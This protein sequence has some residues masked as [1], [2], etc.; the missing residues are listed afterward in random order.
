MLCSNL[1]PLIAT[2]RNCWLLLHVPLKFGACIVR[3][4]SPSATSSWSTLS[5]EPS[6][7]SGTAL[8]SEMLGLASRLTGSLAG[9]WFDV[10]EV[11]AY[12]RKVIVGVRRAREA[13]NVRTSI[14]VVL[15]AVNCWEGC[16]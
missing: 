16:G 7:D 15:G 4:F 14:V 8:V 6:E 9:T 11:E 12:F 3:I 10:V 13:R 1:G 2:S 5:N